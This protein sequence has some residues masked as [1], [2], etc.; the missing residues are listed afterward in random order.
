MSISDMELNCHEIVELLSDYID[1]DMD[2]E[3]RAHM[4]QHLEDCVPCHK[5]LDDLKQ[6]IDMVRQLRCE[7]LP[8]EVRQ[9]LH[10]FLTTKIAK[11]G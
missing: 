7:E 3:T 1:G 11:R 2:V 4:E 5:F 8:A 9:R 6:S 10:T